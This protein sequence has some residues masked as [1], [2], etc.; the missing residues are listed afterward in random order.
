VSLASA[1]QQGKR[2]K[3]D[4][5][6]IKCFN[7][8]ALGHYATQCPRKKNKGEA[9]NSKAAPAKLEKEVEDDDDCAMS[10]HVPLQK[11]WGDIDM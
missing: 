7:C 8:W 5:S 9:S 4:I 10:A 2:K 1:E 3:K 6:K 11:R